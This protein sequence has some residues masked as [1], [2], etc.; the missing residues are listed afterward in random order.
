[1]PGADEKGLINGLPK[2]LFNVGVIV[3]INVD[4]AGF[5]CVALE[6]C[7]I[8]NT[9]LIFEIPKVRIGFIAVFG[10]T[11]RHCKLNVMKSLYK[12]VFCG[13]SCKYLDSFS[14]DNLYVGAYKLIYIVS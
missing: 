10:A 11:L 8:I 9:A 7:G 12:I 3:D 6:I 5:P 14:G 2:K 13:L 4:V 1:M